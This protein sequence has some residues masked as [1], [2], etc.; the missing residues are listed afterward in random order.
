VKEQVQ[1]SRQSL[2]N[3]D[4]YRLELDFKVKE[5]K[6]ASEKMLYEVKENTLSDFQSTKQNFLNTSTRISLYDPENILKLGYAMISQ[7]GVIKEKFSDLNSDKP[8]IIRMQDGEGE[9]DKV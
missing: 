5:Y 4:K 6:A 9:F 2:Q 7:D 8:I 3:L 1:I